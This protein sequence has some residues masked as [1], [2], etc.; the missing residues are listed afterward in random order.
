MESIRQQKVASLLKKEIGVIFQQRSRDLFGGAFITI[1]VVRM[2]P[3]LGLA[4]VYLSFLA[5]KDKDK[6]LDLVKIQKGVIKKHL[7][8]SV[9]K[10]MRRIPQLNFYLDDSAEYAQEI[11]SLL[12]GPSPDL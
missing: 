5:V 8:G 9:G 11:D 7:S 6:L 3:D 4:K 2:S 10:S 1:T 12:K